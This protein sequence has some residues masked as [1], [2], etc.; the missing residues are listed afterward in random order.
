MVAEIGAQGIG[1]DQAVVNFLRHV[2]VDDGAA[3]LAERGAQQMRA[4]S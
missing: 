3:D 4:S 2:F 1:E